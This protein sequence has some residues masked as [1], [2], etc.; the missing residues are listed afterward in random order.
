VRISSVSR[1]FHVLVDAFCSD[2]VAPAEL[3]ELEAI[4]R[5]DPQARRF[6]AA[7][8]RMHAELFFSTLAEHA[9]HSAQ[10]SAAPRAR[11]PAAGLLGGAWHGAMACFTQIVPLSYLITAAL[12]SVALSIASLF[13]PAR[14]AQ[15]SVSGHSEPGPRAEK[16]GAITGLVDCRW[17]DPT[18]ATKCAAPVYVGQR[19]VLASGLLEI[20]YDGG[21]EVI[22][23][24]PAVY[25]VDARSGGFLSVGRLTVRVE[26]KGPSQGSRAGGQGSATGGSSSGA[27]DPSCFT[28]RTP[29]AVLTSSGER[30]GRDL[31]SSTEFGV[32]VVSPEVSRAYVFRGRIAAQVA[33]GGRNGELAV[34]VDEQQG[35]LLREGDEGRKTAIVRDDSQPNPNLFAHRVVLPV[36]GDLRQVA[37]LKDMGAGPQR[38]FVAVGTG[39]ELDLPPLAASPDGAAAPS[40]VTYTCRLAFALGDLVPTTAMLRG[41]YFAYNYVSAIRLNGKSIAPSNRINPRAVKESGE[42]LS[43][44]GFVPGLNVL[45]IDVNNSVVSGV[46]ENGGMLWLRP[47]LSGIRPPISLLPVTKDA[48]ARAA[49]QDRSLPSGDRAAVKAGKVGGEAPRGEQQ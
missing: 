44:E 42:F 30:S 40:G 3:R 9:V 8:C 23:Q 14:P 18:T 46:V 48:G 6:F 38:H 26:K 4:L 5:Q 2:S 22:L 12:L 13:P 25:A 47:E 41:R 49:T 43:R 28:I 17:G 16:L 7:Y 34:P 31:P 33:G 37:W 15:F 45:E 35:V 1:R 32:V 27:S 11:S 21:A 39:E 29:A 19:F 20:T 10:R 36:G 24:G